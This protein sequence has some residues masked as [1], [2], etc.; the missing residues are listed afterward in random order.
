M[1]IDE[2]Y[3][4]SIEGQVRNKKTQRVLKTWVAGRDY[5]YCR[6]GGA[7]SPKVSVHSIV[8]SLFLPQPTIENAEIDHIDRNKKNNHASNL[9]W[10][11]RSIN[12]LNKNAETKPRVSSKTNELYISLEPNGKYRVQVKG[13]YHGIFKTIEEAK[14]FRDTLINVSGNQERQ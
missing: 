12:Q 10:V 8:A 7:G 9:R 2:N 4:C 1:P 5:L 11:S 13:V 6:K 3:E 14:T